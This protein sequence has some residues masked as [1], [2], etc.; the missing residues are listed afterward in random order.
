MNYYPF[1]FM[2]FTILSV[3]LSARWPCTMKRAWTTPGTKNASVNIMLMIPCIGLPQRKTA[4]GGS[5][6]ANR[7]LIIFPSLNRLSY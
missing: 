5:R 1:L 6:I 4:T 3:L 7:Y 2:A